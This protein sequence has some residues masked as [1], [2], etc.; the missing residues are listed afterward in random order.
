[1]D[2]ETKPVYMP[3]Q[4]AHFKPKDIHSLKVKGWR[5]I[6]YATNKEIK[7]GVAV[8]LSDKIDFKTKKITR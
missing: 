5:K 1:M 2:K 4:E 6:F 8:L 7:A 3:L